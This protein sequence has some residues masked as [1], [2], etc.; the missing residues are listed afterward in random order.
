MRSEITSEAITA[1]L[2]AL[3]GTTA[4]QGDTQWDRESQANVPKFEAVCNWVYNRLYEADRSYDS[5]YWS[6]KQTARMVVNA[7]GDLAILF[8]CGHSD[9]CPVCGGSTKGGE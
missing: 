2:D 4:P 1:V 3:V 8:H 9:E 7:A 6:E 5:P